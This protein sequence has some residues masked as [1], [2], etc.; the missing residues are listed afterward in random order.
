MPSYLPPSGPIK[1]YKEFIQ[2]FELMCSQHLAVRQFQV[3]ELSDID[4]ES[5]VD[6]P[7]QYPLVFLVPQQ[8]FMDRYGKLTLGFSLIV[9][10]IAK[11]QEDLQV[12]T[13]NNTLMIIQDL[14][15]RILLTTPT[16]V[17]FSV[18]TPVGVT[19]FVERFKNNLAGWTAEINVE[20][21]SPFD[22]CNSAFE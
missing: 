7:T 20:L 3:G 22:F 16:D 19:P 2:F 15:S 4:V 12:N 8:S 21:K 6:T 9:A 14:L 10:D 13:H 1:T 18:E 11:N 17:D 5:N